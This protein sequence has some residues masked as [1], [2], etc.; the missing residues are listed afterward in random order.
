M[1]HYISLRKAFNFQ[2]CYNNMCQELLLLL[3]PLG[4]CMPSFQASHRAH[5]LI[6][7]LFSPSVDLCKKTP[8]RRWCQWLKGLSVNL[9]LIK[10]KF[11][12]SILSTIQY[13]SKLKTPETILYHSFLFNFLCYICIHD[14]ITLLP[15]PDACKME[16]VFLELQVPFLCRIFCFHPCESKSQVLTLTAL[17]NLIYTHL[18]CCWCTELVP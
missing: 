17:K 14:I 2:T 16:I 15:G 5:P 3:F 13:Q 9:I 7:L 18:R 6:L 10:F 11:F 8:A 4:P 12:S 1:F